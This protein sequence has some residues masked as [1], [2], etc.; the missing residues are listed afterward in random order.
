MSA[1]AVIRALTDRILFISA[2]KHYLVGTQWDSSNEYSVGAQSTNWVLSKTLP[3]S[4]RK[5]VLG[6]LNKLIWRSGP[7]C[8][9]RR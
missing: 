6:L 7:S 4:T 2:P 1:A 8:S 3:M 9:K 5:L